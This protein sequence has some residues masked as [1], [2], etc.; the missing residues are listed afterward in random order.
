MSSAQLERSNYLMD[1]H[2]E[3]GQVNEGQ[4][5]K[6]FKSLMELCRLAGMSVIHRNEVIDLWVTGTYQSEWKGWHDHG[7]YQEEIN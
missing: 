3:K 1:Y 4:V 2:K 7:Y 6:A 5:D